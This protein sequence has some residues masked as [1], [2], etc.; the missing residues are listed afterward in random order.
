VVGRST[1]YLA[2]S[3]VRV[4]VLVLGVAACGVDVAGVLSDAGLPVDTA[5]HVIPDASRDGTTRTPDAGVDAAHSA[6]ATHELDAKGHVDAGSDATEKDSGGH[7]AAK[8]DAMEGGSGEKD[9]GEKDGSEIDGSAHDDASMDAHH[10]DAAT[11][12]AA[13]DV[14][15]H[16]A[17]PKD[18][19]SDALTVT[20]P[21]PNCLFSYSCGSATCG[22]NQTC[23]DQTSCGACLPG[24]AQCG[25]DLHDCDTSLSGVGNCGSCGNVCVC[26]LTTPIPSC[27]PS[28]SSWECHCAEL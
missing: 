9:A 12:D 14:G 1:T 26:P 24:Y 6:D 25:L 19:S 3:R 4:L 10:E 27:L 22:C 5:T 7:D 11:L 2:A 8:H 13:K 16:D 15:T 18:A 28:G 20:N 23:D 21:P 17:H